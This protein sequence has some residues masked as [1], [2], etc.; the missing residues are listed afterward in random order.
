MT[1]SAEKAALEGA[2]AANSAYAP[3]EER[4]L[5]QARQGKDRGGEKAAIDAGTSHPV[6]CLTAIRGCAR[7]RG[8]DDGIYAQPDRE[9][10]QQPIDLDGDV[11]PGGHRL[12]VA[13]L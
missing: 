2:L 9:I 13:H 1:S 5:N 12:R 11:R 3:L 4:I 7:S 6:K 10:P 8:S